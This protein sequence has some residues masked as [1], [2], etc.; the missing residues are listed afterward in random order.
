MSAMFIFL[1]VIVTTTKH[2][3]SCCGKPIFASILLIKEFFSGGN[4]QE[5]K[6]LELLG[7]WHGVRDVNHR[8]PRFLDV[9]F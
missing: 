1:P 7:F 6:Q 3:A 5:Q 2:M 9:G 8:T 4:E